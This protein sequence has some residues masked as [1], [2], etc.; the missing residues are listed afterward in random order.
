MNCSNAA[1][2]VREDVE[3][4]VPLDH[5]EAS[6]GVAGAPWGPAWEPGRS[7]RTGRPRYQRAS[8]ILCCVHDVVTTREL[9]ER[10]PGEHARQQHARRPP[11]R[12]VRRDLRPER[13]PRRHSR[14]PRD[15]AGRRRR[16]PGRRS[17]CGCRG[18]SERTGPSSAWSMPTRPATA[19]LEGEVEGTLGSIK[20]RATFRLAEADGR[21][22]IDYDGQAVIGG[23]LARLD[24]RFVEG[25]AGSLISQG[26][27]NLRLATAGRSVGRH[28]ERQ[29]AADQGDSSVTV[30]QLL[31]A[32]IAAGGARPAGEARPGAAGDGRRNRRHAAH[33]RRHLAA[34]GGHGPAPGRPRRA[35]ARRTA[36]CG[37]EP[38]RR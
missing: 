34:R 14:L 8:G 3:G 24:S 28:R 5:R 15:R 33:Q 7:G 27:R 32:S 13:A 2:P 4:D 10:R 35:R 30:R 17:P 38:P 16:V 31:P 18:S 36:R 25:L 19:E 23:P 1:G 21:T 6:V 20:G 26:L 22:T 29:P 9:E 11:R 37:S 12:R